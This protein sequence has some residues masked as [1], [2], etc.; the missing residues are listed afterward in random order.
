MIIK[1]FKHKHGNFGDDL[2]PWLW[3]K[4][5]LGIEGIDK[6]TYFIGIGTLLNEKLP[7]GK[8]VIFGAGFGYGTVP[9]VDEHWHTYAVRGYDTARQLGIS[10]DLVITDAAVL[11]R[12][13]EYPQAPTQHKIGFMPHVDSCWNCDWDTIC[14]ELDLHFIDAAWGVE[15]VLLEMQACD[16]II[17]E[18]MHGAIVAD[19]LRIPWVP[20]V[21]YDHILNS[22]WVDWLTTMK[23]EYAPQAIHPFWDVDSKLDPKFLAKTRLKRLLIKM[24]ADSSN[25]TPP[26]PKS[27]KSDYEKTK[28]EIQNVIRNDRYYLSDDSVLSR[29]V[30]RF[31]E[32]LHQFKRDYGLG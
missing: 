17:T 30:D 13:T 32:K 10:E 26:Y 22:K 20:V 3:P 27:N 23:L 4:L 24:G 25:W 11:L 6:D 21:I 31:S 18:A 14:K 1:Y 29:H 5:I 8:K 19:A 12:L 2:N 9:V 16:K 15:R 7:P 28:Q